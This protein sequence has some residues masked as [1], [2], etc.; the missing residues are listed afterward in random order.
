MRWLFKPQATVLRR[1]TF[2]K[3]TSRGQSRAE[4]AARYPLQ[5]V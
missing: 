3:G 1:R 5:V 4:K 2:S